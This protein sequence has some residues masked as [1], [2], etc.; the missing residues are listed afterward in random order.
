MLLGA[1]FRLSYLVSAEAAI[2]DPSSSAFDMEL[3]AQPYF[4]IDQ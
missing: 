2:S 4:S 3:W 1:G